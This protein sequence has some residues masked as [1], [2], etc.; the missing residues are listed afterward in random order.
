MSQFSQLSLAVELDNQATLENFFA[1]SGSTHQQALNLLVDQTE[2]YVY[3]SGPSGV[4][5]SHLLQAICQQG[6]L[7]VYLPLADIRHYPAEDIFEGLESVSLLCLDDF[8]LVADQPD[9]QQP[10]FNLFN[11]C[12]ETATRLVV[13]AQ[14][15]PDQLGVFLPDLLSRLKSG[16]VLQLN[17]FDDEDLQHLLQY[18]ARRRGLELSEDVATFMLSRLPRQTQQLMH[19]LEMLDKASLQEQRRLTVPFIKDVLA[20]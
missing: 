7:A 4:G 10:L 9:W 12:H 19:S 17:S 3:L 14:R 15:A 6:E 2:Q 18:R 5:L 8:H 11:R 1:P 13:A 16:I 20:L